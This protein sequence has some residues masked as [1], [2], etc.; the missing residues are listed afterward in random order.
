MNNLKILLV[1]L[2]CAMSIPIAGQ[3]FNETI[4]KEVQLKNKSDDYLLIVDNVFGSIELE[5]YSVHL[6]KLKLKNL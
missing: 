4:T 5:G 3:S 1:A 6:L 2:C